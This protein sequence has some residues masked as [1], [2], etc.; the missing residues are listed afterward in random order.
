MKRA[1]ADPNLPIVEGYYKAFKDA[2]TAPPDV[3]IIPESD[4]WCQSHIISNGAKKQDR[5][6]NKAILVSIYENV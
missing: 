2:G 6:I 3:Q 1:G 5:F 4:N